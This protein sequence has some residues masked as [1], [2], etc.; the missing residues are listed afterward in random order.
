MATFTF[1][2]GM[3]A[4]LEGA[5]TINAPKASGPSPKQNS[6]VRIELVG[7]RGEISHQYFRDPGRAVLA[8]GA[9]E[10]VFERQGLSMFTQPAPFPLDYFLG[11]LENQVT[12]VATIEDARRSFVIA[13]A[14]YQSAREDRPVMLSW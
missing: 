4:T 12:P 6:V 5:W 13:M 3:I 11:I 8:A 7:T 9:G 1:Q 2:N 10:W 14:A